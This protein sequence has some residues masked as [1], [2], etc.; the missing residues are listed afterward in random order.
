M[1][2]LIVSFLIV[3]LATCMVC[4]CTPGK[5]SS[6]ETSSSSSIS[7]VSSSSS[8]SSETSVS[9]ES[10]SS[11]ESSTS[12]EEKDEP[13]FPD[14]GFDVDNEAVYPEIWG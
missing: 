6:S 14:N 1:K 2:K 13:D 8:L 9:S 4:A 12:S 7:S 10:S 11:V 5:Q 3:I